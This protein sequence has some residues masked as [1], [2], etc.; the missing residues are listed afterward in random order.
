VVGC[1][2]DG[3]GGGVLLLLQAEAEKSLVRGMAALALAG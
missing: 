1:A 3:G 2:D